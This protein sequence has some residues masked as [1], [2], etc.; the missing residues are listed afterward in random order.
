M[1]I[2]SDRKKRGTGKTALVVD[3]NRAIREMLAHAFLTDGFKTCGEAANGREAI[4][5][6]KQINPDVVV[7][8]LSMPL[9]NGLSAASELREIFPNTPIILFTLY[10]SEVSKAAASA[11]GVN[12]VLQKTEPLSEVIE[13]VHLLMGVSLICPV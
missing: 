7:L 9:M 8:D 10:G 6:A 4:V 11:A 13:K 2:E 5:L 3:D 1:E 12:L